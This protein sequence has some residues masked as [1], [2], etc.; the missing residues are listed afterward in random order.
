MWQYGLVDRLATPIDTFRRVALP[1][2]RSTPLRGAK[3]AANT[4]SSA[5]TAKKFEE[6]G[7]R[8]ETP[9]QCSELT[10]TFNPC[11]QG[12]SLPGSQPARWRTAR[13]FADPDQSVRPRPAVVKCDGE[14]TGTD[15]FTELEKVRRSGASYLRS[16]PP[17]TKMN[18]P[19]RR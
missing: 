1:P 14:R 17:T 12:A 4:A 2:T 5:L 15:W 6:P 19:W 10:G 16:S 18:S 3:P 9:W 11:R 7:R 13:R 8:A